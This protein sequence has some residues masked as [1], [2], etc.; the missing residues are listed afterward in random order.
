MT[1]TA[2]ASAAEAT[3]SDRLEEAPRPRRPRRDPRSRR[4]VV[5]AFFV[6]FSVLAALR[7]WNTLPNGL[8]EVVTASAAVGGS[9]VGLRTPRRLAFI[10]IFVGL[11]FLF[12]LV[13]FL[14]ILQSAEPAAAQKAWFRLLFSQG[15]GLGCYLVAADRRRIRWFT[16]GG[17]AGVGLIALGSIGALPLG[18]LPLGLTDDGGRLAGPVGDPNFFGQFLA[19][20]IAIGAAVVL[21]ERRFVVRVPGLLAVAGIIVAVLRTES[22]GTLLAVVLIGVVLVVQAEHTARIVVVL[23]AITAVVFV[24]TD[25]E[26]SA[27]ERLLRAPTS[28]GQALDTGSPDDTA[29]GGRV[30]EGIAA[31]RMTLDHPV[32]GVGIGNYRFRYQDYAADIGIDGRAEERDAHNRHLEVAAESGL[33]G[34]V[35]WAALII[36]TAVRAFGALRSRWVTPDVRMATLAWTGAFVGW[37]A[38]SVFLHDYQPE[39]EWLVLG[40]VFAAAEVARASELDELAAADAQWEARPAASW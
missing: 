27:F 37:L 21:R 11:S 3:A 36:A 9:M 39:V 16:F 7:H 23:V 18:G 32:L 17:L 5:I 19:V 12:L 28:V 2:D 20:G 25:L 26:N 10:R 34:A 33:V 1:D 30:S 29:V 14:S 22:R 13:S 40:A 35:A 15:L 6:S 24:T 31:V 38:T 8:F 4:G